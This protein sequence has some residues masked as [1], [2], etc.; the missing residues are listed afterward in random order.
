MAPVGAA[1]RRRFDFGVAMPDD[2][3]PQADLVARVATMQGRI[4]EL[5]RALQANRDVETL[6]QDSEER[7]RQVTDSINEVFWM[8]DPRKDKH[9][10]HQQGLRAHLGTHV[11]ER[12]GAAAVVHREHPH[13]GPRGGDRGLSEAKG[14]HLRHRIS[15]R[16][17]RRRHPLDPRQSLS[18]PRRRRRNLPHRR[19]R[20][21]HH[22]QQG[23]RRALPPGHRHHRR[24]V[25]D[26]RSAQGRDAVHQQG[27]RAGLGAHPAAASSSGRC[28][29]SRAS[30]R[31]TATR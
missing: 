21:G 25:L 9:A 20:P 30:T 11:P 17:Q 7:F 3:K 29:S 4:E 1:N 14:R 10:V 5:E 24:G 23:Q 19:R 28:R 18:D 6:L 27:L 15:H 12:H 13:C 8:T 2:V 16:A 31:S 26:D 22:G